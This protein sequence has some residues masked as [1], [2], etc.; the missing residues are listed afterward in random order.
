MKMK[1]VI[2]A[3]AVLLLKTAAAQN[4][5][6]PIYQIGIYLGGAHYQVRD[7]IVAP[8]RWDGFGP[9]AT[10]S[11]AYVND[12][13]RHDIE[14][15]TTFAFPSNRYDHS[16]MAMELN[17]GLRYLRRITGSESQGQL[18]LGGLLDW[19]F[20]FQF[21]DSWDDSHGYW[22]NAYEL[23]PAVRWSQA[24]GSKH[25]LAV[26]FNFPLLALVARPPE[27]RYYDQERLPKEILS[28]PHE[29]MELTSVHEYISFGLRGCYTCKVS[30]KVTLG[31]SYLLN[32]KTFSQPK[33]ISILCNT[34]SLRLLCTLGKIREEES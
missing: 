2:F 27:H 12:K 16:A 29:N 34:M 4:V 23:G 25:R 18:H 17:L 14:L 19:S 3:I 7:D 1:L 28:K 21:Y 33:R 10:L 24:L 32:Y 26:S 31:V 6:K 5:S 11:Y 15:R 8:L 30:R 9:V 13:V 22:L 20:N